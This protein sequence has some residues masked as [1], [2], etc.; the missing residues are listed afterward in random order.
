MIPAKSKNEP[1]RAREIAAKARAYERM[2]MGGMAEVSTHWMPS[3]KRRK[4]GMR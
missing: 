3:V 2:V 4:V 1:T